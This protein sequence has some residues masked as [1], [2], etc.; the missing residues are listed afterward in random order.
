MSG[1]TS[2]H[3]QPL[4][5]AERIVRQTGTCGGKPRV[6]GTRIRVQDIYVW[7]HVQGK[8]P[9]EIVHDFPQLSMAD[10]YAALAYFWIYRDELLAD[11]EQRRREFDRLKQSTPSLLER[12]LTEQGSHDDEDHSLPPG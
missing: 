1:T 7:H 9:E 4:T 3:S 10:V 8:S 12:R 6:S 2:N 11:L 5:L